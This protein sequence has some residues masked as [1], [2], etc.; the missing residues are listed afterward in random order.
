MAPGTERRRRAV[1]HPETPAPRRSGQA[2]RD[3]DRHGAELLI[4][5]H[6][7][8]LTRERRRLS[9]LGRQC[10]D[11]QNRAAERL[12]HEQACFHRRPPSSDLSSITATSES[13]GF[14]RDRSTRLSA[15]RDSVRRP[16]V[17]GIRPQS[18]V[19]SSR[20][21]ISRRK[22]VELVRRERRQKPSPAVAD[23]TEPRCPKRVTPDSVEPC[24]ALARLRPSQRGE[25]KVECQ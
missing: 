20:G 5:H 11:E 3:P 4:H 12:Q 2:C 22:S 17:D 13:R 14:H 16:C 10:R 6:S 24:V 1:E 7:G 15:G 9:V 19:P 18:T 8:Q 21:C 25:L 23:A